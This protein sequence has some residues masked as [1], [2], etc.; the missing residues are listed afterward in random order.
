MRTLVAS[1]AA[2][3]VLLVLLF[4]G[5]G[6]LSSPGPL[7]RAVAAHRVLPAPA[8]VAVAVGAA[9]LL[10]GGAGALALVRADH[11]L[12][13]AAL[14]GSMLLL[15]IFGGYGWY[16]VATG[17]GGPC[18][19]S[20]ADVP[21]SGWVVARAF[22]L[23]GL[24]LVGQLLAESVLPLNRPDIELITV[25]LA[26]AAVGCLLWQLPAAMYDPTAPA[27]PPAATARRLVAGG[28]R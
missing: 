11:E 6:H 4:A 10:L 3:T 7:R 14:A 18:G 8:V 12:L 24:A 17:A 16:V 25:L 20:A 26:A 22:V 2:D 19:C 21:M 1:V 27:V 15:A 13:V 9:E 23:S 5:A 28:R